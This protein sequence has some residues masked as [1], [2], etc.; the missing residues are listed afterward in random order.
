MF[1][2]GHTIVAPANVCCDSTVHQKNSKKIHVQFGFDSSIKSYTSLTLLQN[3]YVG[4]THE[5]SEH[6]E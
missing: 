1:E 5:Q 2:T 3:V 6:Y 4:A